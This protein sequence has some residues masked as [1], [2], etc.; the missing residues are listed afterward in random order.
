MRN[1]SDYLMLGLLLIC[2][3]L[4]KKVCYKVLDNTKVS[5]KVIHAFT[6]FLEENALSVVDYSDVIIALCYNLLQAKTDDLKSTWGIA[7]ELSKLVMSLYDESAN[8]GKAKD[9]LNAEK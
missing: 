1:T 6:H 2:M 9:K 7:D 8:S 4:D 3:R 5:R